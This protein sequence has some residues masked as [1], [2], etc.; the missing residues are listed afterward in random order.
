MLLFELAMIRAILP[1]TDAI[2]A[3]C[4][5]V[6]VDAVDTEVALALVGCSA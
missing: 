2:L 6:A 4:V 1:G 5:V 3:G